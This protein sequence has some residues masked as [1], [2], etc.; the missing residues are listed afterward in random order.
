M[1]TVASVSA[2]PFISSL[3]FSD[4]LPP[5]LN[6]KKILLVFSKAKCDV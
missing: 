1:E 4:K 6:V 5:E 3:N 2:A